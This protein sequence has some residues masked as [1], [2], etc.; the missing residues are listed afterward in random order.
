MIVEGPTSGKN[1]VGSIEHTVAVQT[2]FLDEQSKHLLKMS[3]KI[4]HLVKLSSKVSTFFSDFDQA[5]ENECFDT[6]TIC[7]SK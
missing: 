3:E 6:L 2:Q 7:A 4:D 5:L 1:I